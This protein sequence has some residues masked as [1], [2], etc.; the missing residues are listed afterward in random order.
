MKRDWGR[1]LKLP[2]ANGEYR[3]SLCRTWK[4]P[5]HFNKNK[6]QKS[7]LN[8]A[9]KECMRVKCRQYGLPKKYGFTYDGFLN[10]LEAQNNKCDCCGKEF[11]NS[12]EYKDRVCVDHNHN[13]GEIR[14]LVCHKCNLAA[15]NVNDS[16]SYALQVARYLEKWN[17]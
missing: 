7:G 3:C 13:T 15:G 1:N 12:G 4:E 2:N 14:G 9:C 11:Q 8:Y 16:S 10:K 17:C 6:F 5:K